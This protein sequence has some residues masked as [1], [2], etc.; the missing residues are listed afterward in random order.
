MQNIGFMRR[1]AELWQW[2]S[3]NWGGFTARVGWSNAHVAGAGGEVLNGDGK[4][5]DPSML[6][7]GL[8][9]THAMESGDELWLGF[10]YQEHE[11][12]AALDFNCD[13]S[14]DDTM[15][16]AGRYIHDWQNGHST[17]ISVA[18]EEMSWDWDSCS[19]TRM[20]LQTHKE[21]LQLGFQTGKE[22]LQLTRQAIVLT[23]N[24]KFI[25]FPVSTTSRDR[26]IFVSCT[27]KPMT[28]IAVR[29][30][31][32]TRMIPVRSKYPFGLFYT[33]PAGTELRFVYGEVDNDANSQ[34]EFG[35]NSSYSIEKGGSVDA[36]QFGVVQWF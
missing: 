15:R 22:L 30:V 13:D 3:P 5:L 10:G 11:E 32:F 33:M 25:W 8:A 18:Y 26:L 9:Y 34:N 1:K 19:R 27:W 24:V 17:R 36:F 12:W 31:E 29:A 4:E 16:L 28:M 7:I 2:M 23:L 14:S 6:S 35:I 20:G 21:I